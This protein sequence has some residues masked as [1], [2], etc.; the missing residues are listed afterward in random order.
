[1]CTSQSLRSL[2]MAILIENLYVFAGVPKIMQGMFGS[3][4]QKLVGGKKLFNI[5]ISIILIFLSFFKAATAD[6]INNYWR[7]IY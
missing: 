5:T 3:I 7:S 1:M 6:N 4:R 2:R